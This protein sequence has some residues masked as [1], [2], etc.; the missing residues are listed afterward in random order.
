MPKV[1]G[2]VLHGVLDE[3]Y[4]RGQAGLPGTMG[5]TATP[6]NLRGCPRWGTDGD[7]MEMGLDS[8]VGVY[9][10]ETAA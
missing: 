2:G 7:V 3:N 1:L 5:R 4:E 8:G 10:G 9:G 6:M